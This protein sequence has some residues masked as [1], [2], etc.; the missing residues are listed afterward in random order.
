MTSKEEKEIRKRTVA[1]EVYKK[2]LDLD[3]ITEREYKKA[4]KLEIKTK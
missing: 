3:L 4:V 1:L 2:L